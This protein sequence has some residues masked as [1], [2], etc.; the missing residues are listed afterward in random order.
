M[1]SKIKRGAAPS[2]QSPLANPHPPRY[3]PTM[4]P[5]QYLDGSIRSKCRARGLRLSTFWSRISYGWSLERALETPVRPWSKYRRKGEP[6]PKPLIP[7][8]A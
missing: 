3:N 2:Y 4:K 5:G 1:V 8:R 7:R 6:D